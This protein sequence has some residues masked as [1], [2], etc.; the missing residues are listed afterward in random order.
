MLT[1]KPVSHLATLLTKET[2]S[3]PVS[4]PVSLLTRKPVSQPVSLLA[5]KPVS[6]PAMLLTRKP[7][8]EVLYNCYVCVVATQEI[9]GIN[10]ASVFQYRK[11]GF[12][13]ENH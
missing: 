5:R 9:L 6:Q 4:Q 1:I 2:V 8:R 3:Q 10:V 7:A 11:G 13:E 12:T